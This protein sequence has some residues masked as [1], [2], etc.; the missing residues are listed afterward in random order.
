M[1][2]PFGSLRVITRR[3]QGRRHEV[4]IL[5]GGLTGISTALHLRRRYWQLIEK[6]QRL[7]GQA[8]SDS[9]AGF[10][11]DKTGH[12]LHLRDEHT[13]K[14]VA[15]AFG[16]GMT[17]T[18]RRARIFA[19][20]VLTRYPFQ[21]NLHGQ[22]PQVVE[23]CL[24]GF[25]EAWL[26]R[27]RESRATPSVPDPDAPSSNDGSRDGSRARQSSS[28]SFEEF[29]LEQFGPGIARHFM[30]PY[31]RKLWGVEPREMVASWCSRFVPKPCL[32]EVVA[33]ALGTLSAELGYNTSFLYPRAGGIESF[34]RALVELLATQ[35]AGR[36]EIAVGA[37]V[38]A[39]DLTRK[40]VWVGGERLP[41]E[42]LVSTL[43]LPELIGRIRELPAHIEQWAAKLRWT[44]VRYLNV[45]A[46]SAPPAD[47]HWIYV[48]EE[49]YPF[50]RAGVYSNVAQ[51]M[52]PPG[53]S[54]LYVELSLRGPRPTGAAVDSL[55]GEVTRALVC[56]SALRSVEDVV[57][58]DLAELEY[59]YVIFDEHHAEATRRILG[60]LS[61]N[62]VRSC[63]RYGSWTY[64]AMED[65]I[66]AGRDTAVT[67]E[68]GPD[69]LH[70]LE[71]T[72][73]ARGV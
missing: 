51:S 25:I 38:D 58:A 13:K 53:G 12:W 54:S 73:G 33:G 46:K 39:V 43:P 18:E 61:A 17:S 47:Y 69:E 27:E 31:N 21:A 7:G 10:T 63:G 57:V 32:R 4:V 40:E 26:R 24:L 55:V 62:D 9:R 29:I 67:L 16:N 68:Q 50:Y 37:S 42:S 44:R 15:S 30:I 59:A 45:G 23:E 19:N 35:Q 72:R 5:G 11:F 41:Y 65:C 1:S 28:L 3:M 66:L 70:G 20:G 60:W 49:R 8:T 64:N 48:P 14:L 2:F 36:G 6:E 56:A 22:P 71:T 52:A 34:T